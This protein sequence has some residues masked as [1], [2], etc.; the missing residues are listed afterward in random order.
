MERT[1]KCSDG[2]GRDVHVG[3]YH[4]GD[5]LEVLCQQ[6]EHLGWSEEDSHD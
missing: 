3:D 2:C 6:C 5:E 4:E 1:L